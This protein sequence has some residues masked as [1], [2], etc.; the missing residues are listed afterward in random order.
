MRETL[1]SELLRGVAWTPGSSPDG[2]YRVVTYSKSEPGSMAENRQITQNVWQ[3]VYAKA[4]AS[5]KLLAWSSW[6]Y[7]FP[8]GADTKYDLLNAATYKD[9]PSAIQGYLPSAADFSAAHPDGN[10]VSAVDQLRGA[11][12]TSKVMVSR[13]IATASKNV[14]RQ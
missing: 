1:G 10:L 8:R 5:G 12:K 11:R 14:T 9:L 2:S 6:S 4:A 13:I 7:V 3:P